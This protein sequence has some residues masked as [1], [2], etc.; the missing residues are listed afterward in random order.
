MT[1]LHPLLR[2]VQ[3]GF[4]SFKAAN[5]MKLTPS[6]DLGIG[7]FSLSFSSTNRQIAS[8]ARLSPCLF[9]D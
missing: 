1:E 9:Q 3:D 4:P 5:H 2:L 8:E 6:R 7:I